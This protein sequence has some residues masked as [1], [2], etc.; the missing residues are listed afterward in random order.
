[1]IIFD[2]P[3]APL[4]HGGWSVGACNNGRSKFKSRIDALRF[5]INAALEVQQQGDDALI[6][7]E[8]VDGR[9]RMFDHR[10]RG[11]V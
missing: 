7:I 2:I 6:T 4:R 1:M 5:A 3:F 8:G 11:L 9:W 10:A